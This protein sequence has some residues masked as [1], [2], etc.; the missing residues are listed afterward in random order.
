MSVATLILWGGNV[1]V[2]QMVPW[3]LD[4]I[5]PAGTFWA[6]AIMTIPALYITFRLLPETKGK[7]LEEIEKFWKSRTRK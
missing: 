4:T 5:K 6:F 7:S 3:A 2:G 1:F